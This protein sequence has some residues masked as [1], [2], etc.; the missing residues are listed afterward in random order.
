MISTI[1]LP[2]SSHA[3]TGGEAGNPDAP[4]NQN[5]DFGILFEEG[6][7][8]DYVLQEQS[9]VEDNLLWRADVPAA[10]GSIVI[11]ST[12]ATTISDTTNFFK[13]AG[14]T[15]L[16]TT[17]NLNIDMPANNR[18]RY[19]GAETVRM[20]IW[21]A[22]TVDSATN[23]QQIAFKVWK[24]DSSAGTGALDDDSEI[25]GTTG[26][27][28]NFAAVTLVADE[29]MDENDYIEIHVRNFSGAND[30]TLDHMKLMVTAFPLSAAL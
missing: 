16:G 19:T 12:A 9:S 28:N 18:L 8:T 3:L 17:E 6:G 27:A 23:N 10:T 30:V 4:G 2:L 26:N 21:A 7:Q 5:T 25:D 24:W 11:S 1:A 15:A 29:L 14:T 20:Q 22:L 13:L